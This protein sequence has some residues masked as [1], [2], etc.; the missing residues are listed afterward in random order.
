LSRFP[1]MLQ[2]LWIMHMKP[3]KG[4]V[5]PLK[6]NLF[7]GRARFK[8]QRPSRCSCKGWKARLPCSQTLKLLT[9]GFSSIF[10]WPSVT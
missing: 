4:Y 8:P 9:G 1:K 6:G 10:L 3:K 7:S 2:G 5:G